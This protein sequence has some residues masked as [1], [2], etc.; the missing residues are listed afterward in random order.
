MNA[1]R[2]FLCRSISLYSVACLLLLSKFAIAEEKIADQWDVHVKRL[3][4]NDNSNEQINLNYSE[5]YKIFDFEF[6]SQNEWYDELTGWHSEDVYETATV[7]TGLP[8]P[9]VKM[10][11]INNLTLPLGNDKSLDVY[12][13]GD[14]IYI[15]YA[16]STY[17]ISNPTSTTLQIR[18]VSNGVAAIQGEDGTSYVWSAGTQTTISPH[19]A[20]S[21]TEIVGI[22]DGVVGVQGSDGTVHI[23]Q[24]GTQTEF[25]SVYAE[26]NEIIGMDNGI[27]AIEKADGNKIIWQ[28]EQDYYIDA[29]LYTNSMDVISMD[30]GL[31]AFKDGSGNAHVWQD[32]TLYHVDQPYTAHSTEFVGIDHG[33]IALEYS[34][35]TLGV[36]TEGETDI[37]DTPLYVNDMEFVGMACGAIAIELSNGDT[38]LWKDGEVSYIEQ[39]PLI[40]STVIGMDDGVIAMQG[41]DG[42]VILWQDGTPDYID[43]PNGMYDLEVLAMDGGV[44]ILQDASGDSYIWQNGQ[45]YP[46]ET[47]PG[48]ESTQI[49]GIGD[50]V[51]GIQAEDGTSYVWKDGV[52]H[53][54][55]ANDGEETKIYDVS[56]GIVAITSTDNRTYI[57]QD[58]VQY[59][60]PMDPDGY[61][62]INAMDDGVVVIATYDSYWQPKQYVWQNGQFVDFGS[63]FLQFIAVV[64][65]EMYFVVNNQM[66]IL[67]EDGTISTFID[68]F[69][70]INDA[71]IAVDGKIY[72]AGYDEQTNTYSRYSV[73]P[74][75]TPTVVS[76]D[77]FDEIEKSGTDN[78]GNMTHEEV[79]SYIT[80][81]ENTG[82]EIATS[83]TSFTS[84]ITL[85]SYYDS[86]D[87]E[88]DDNY[89]LIEGHYRYTTG[90]DRFTLQDYVTGTVAWNKLYNRRDNEDP[91]SWLDYEEISLDPYEH[92]EDVYITTPWGETYN[93]T[94][95]YAD[96]LLDTQNFAFA[97][98]SGITITGGFTR[99][100]VR[101]LFH[102]A[103]AFYADNPLPEG[104]YPEPFNTSTIF[105]YDRKEGTEKI[106]YA[107][108]SYE[109]IPIFSN[110]NFEKAEIAT[111]VTDA[112]FPDTFELETQNAYSALPANTLKMLT[113]EDIG[114]FYYDLLYSKTYLYS[115][116]PEG[117]DDVEY[118]L[119]WLTECEPCSYTGA[120]E[121]PIDEI[122]VPEP[123]SIALL[124]SGLVGLV[125]RRLKK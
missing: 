30:E 38:Q 123:F 81:D 14:D 67:H 112:Y 82:D 75:G 16:G 41:H 80:F 3:T 55:Q 113:Y 1:K 48:V 22:S 85:L 20:G 91:V 99:E 120:P 121:D 50:G 71:L 27:V 73:T 59:T 34:D 46:V 10:P 66:K 11:G 40:D 15:N 58:G 37:L 43:Q 78:L 106:W 51:V 76:Q 44:V 102:E 18:G 69:E 8:T 70:E 4:F 124:L 28:N 63:D 101:I 87:P 72:F 114:W 9:N 12:K 65:N 92:G 89:D 23:W 94:Q 74:G 111:P 77:Y 53:T 2:K 97:L 116:V 45:K 57:W 31:V 93:L 17:T 83:L 118:Y 104:V 62:Y 42:S 33:I 26:G 117:E 39:N 109:E 84:D 54:I 29:P 96:S 13:S 105:Y 25:V 64:D 68:G 60:V 88:P 47:Q 36:W 86:E 49:I 100:S 108:G 107:D 98:D 32:G 6:I 35:G 52:Q 79:L 103:G 19:I 115:G 119:V 21:D 24:N 56:N 5:S 95:D 110:F 90:L 125:V 61:S 122:G 7:N